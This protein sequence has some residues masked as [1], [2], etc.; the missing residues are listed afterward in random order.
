V[1]RSGV[2]ERQLLAFLDGVAGG[3]SMPVEASVNA[4]YTFTK[5]LNGSLGHKFLCNNK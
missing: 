4:T 1:R 2:D 3:Q 5:R